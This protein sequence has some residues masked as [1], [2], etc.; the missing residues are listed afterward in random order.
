MKQI[1][2][3]ELSKKI[4][5]NIVKE[6]LKEYED[7]QND[8]STNDNIKILASSGRFVEMTFAAIYYVK[9]NVLLD[10][11]NVDVEKLY[12]KI[13]N[14]SRN[15]SGTDDLLYLEIPRV[16][17]ALYTIRSKKRG[18]HRK[19]LDAIVQDRIFIKYSVDWILSSFIFLFHT[20]SDKEIQG[21]IETIVQKKVPLIEEFEDGGSQVLKKL[22]F[23]QKL[24]VILYRQST[25]IT[26]KELKNLSNPKYP[27]EF[28]TNL[29]NL[30]K[31]LLIYINGKNVKINQNGIKEVQEKILKDDTTNAN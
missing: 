2:Q 26:R 21:I 28:V 10:I 25:M 3:N 8:F 29:N 15:K 23:S 27:Q 1:L 31:D 13:R 6:L 18:A 19:D 14:S 22:T 7:V 12:N 20:K 30:Y 4:H 24:L 9:D 5:Q 11:N 17:R 16:A